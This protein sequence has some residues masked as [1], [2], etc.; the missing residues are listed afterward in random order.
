VNGRALAASPLGFAIGVSLGAL[1]G[2]GSILAVPVLVYAAGQSVPQATSSSLVLVIIG[3]LVGIVPHWRNHRVRWPLALVF[4]AVGVIGTAAGSQLN[5]RVDPDLLLLMFA[6]VLAVAGAMMYRSARRGGPRPTGEPRSRLRRGVE[7]TLAG[8][9][10][11]FLTG[12]FGVGGGFVIVPALV[13]VLGVPMTDAAGTS[14]AVILLNSL[15]ALAMRAGNST[16]ESDV[17][18]PFALAT[19]AG[20]AVGARLAGR[21]EPKRLQMAFVGLIGLVAVYVGARATLSLSS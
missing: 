4:A 11:G 5:T 6:G 14:L 21:T 2:G 18:V 9:A 16:I 3:S 12:F 8:S 19:I 13:L 17:V 10:V 1:G 20:V 15:S 7:I